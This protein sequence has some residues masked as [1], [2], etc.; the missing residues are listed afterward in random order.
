MNYRKASASQ[1][2]AVANISGAGATTTSYT[3]TNLDNGDEYIFRIH[4]VSASQ[5][6]PW[7]E[8]VRATPGTT[9]TP[10]STPTPTPTGTLTPTPT[11]TPTP[12]G[13]LTPTP[14]GPP[15]APAISRVVA[16]SGQITIHYTAVSG[17]TR[18]E[19]QHR[20]TGESW[21][22][23]SPEVTVR[24]TDTSY[25]ITGLENG[26]EYQARMRAHNSRGPSDWSIVLNRDTPANT[27]TPNNTPTEGLSKPANLRAEAGNR[28]VTL[29]WDDPGDGTIRGYRLNYRKASASQWPAVFNIPGSGATTTSY[30]VTNLDNGDEYI[31]RIHAVSASQSGPWSEEVRATPGTTPTSTPTPTPTGT[32]TPTPSGPP[33]TPAISRVVAGAGQITIRYTS[34]SGVTRYEFQHRKAGESWPDTSPE[35]TVRDTDTSYT[36]TGLENGATYQVRMR[37]YNSRGPSNWSITLTRDTPTDTPTPTVAPPNP[38]AIKWNVPGN[39]QL[40]IHYQAVS[41]ITRYEFQHR[42]TGESWPDTSP[43]VTVKDTDT[44]YTIT[45]LENGVAYDY[46]MRAYNDGGSSGWSTTGT[47]RM[48]PADTPTPTPTGTLTPTPTPTPTNTPTDTPTPTNTPIPT[49]TPTPTPTPAMLANLRATTGD[50][51]ITLRWDDPKDASITGYYLQQR[52]PGE[53]WPA[54]TE[55]PGPTTHTITGLNNGEAYEFRISAVNS[56]GS[57]IWS[58]MLSARP[59]E[60]HS[61]PVGLRAVAGNGEVTLSW[62][63]PGDASITE[64]RLNYRKA[65]SSHWPAVVN[66]PGAGATTRSYTVTNLDN[67]DEYI[68]RIHAGSVGQSSPW[69][70]EV[71]ATPD[72]TLPTSTPTPTPTGTLMPTPTAGLSKPANLRAEA[73]NRQVTLTWDDPGDR[74]I[75]GYRL[76]Y[77]KAS[78]SQWPAVLNIPGAGATTTS[79]TVTNLDNGDEYIFRIHVVSASQSGPWSE[80]VRAMPGTTPTPTPTGT[81]TPT[82]LRPPP[83]PEFSRVVAGSGQITIN[84]R[85]M[86]GVT[87]YEFQHRKAGESWPDSSPVVTVKD[88][89]TSYTITRLENGVEY[90]VRMRAH[91]SR[92]PSPWSILLIRE[93][94]ANT[95]TPTPTN[96]PTD[97]P[98]NT[99]TPT[100]TNTPT[101]TPADTPM[102]H[103]IVVQGYLPPPA[104]PTPTP[105]RRVVAAATSTPTPTATTAPA[106]PTRTPTPTAMPTT[107]PTPTATA[108]A[109]PTGTPTPTMLP[110]EMLLRTPTATRRAIPTR[111][112]TPVAMLTATATPPT[113]APTA[114]A[115]TPPTSRHTAT[116]TATAAPTATPLLPDRALDAVRPEPTAT[117]AA[118]ALAAAEPTATPVPPPTA[119]AIPPTPTPPAPPVSAGGVNWLLW[120][121][122]G[123]V[124]VA[125]AAGGVY[126]YR[127]RQ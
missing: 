9:P 96:T 97:M 87:R 54:R 110:A 58:A 67:G 46:R 124:V 99:P 56:N 33:F 70:E 123:L 27:P 80:E 105:T 108:P 100:P 21:P 127:R 10:T 65:S 19:F 119:T 91:N 53:P 11:D 69:S 5:S 111:T 52:K 68:F 12:T 71:R 15:F 26:V 93:T 16:G 37:A 66:I 78:A 20:K 38:P 116:A 117:T 85:A 17:V 75:G 13:T 122:I 113:R 89:D 23:T 118:P 64:Y 106:S 86:S 6:G 25:T 104:D 79:Y 126:L 24:D 34:V 62:D 35:V 94:R 47:S 32:L 28:Q 49:S 109:L 48:L 114:T 120:V 76:N 36:I 40:A 59:K 2:P 77:R 115:T 121:V 22:D 88:T 31:F 92:G 3:V 50:R 63:D 112:P 7:S 84:Y 1:W 73:G 8:E 51:Q 74:T 61:K 95:P 103:P 82:P 55:I 90:Q 18:Y 39:G 101:D 60:G 41:G 42:K 83:V 44:S 125:L 57:S 98:A 81:L 107:M 43:V 102:P 29:T 72:G 45:G 14:S 4:A 30:T